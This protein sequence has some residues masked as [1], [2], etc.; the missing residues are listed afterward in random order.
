MGDEIADR[1]AERF[2]GGHEHPVVTHHPRT[3]VPLLFVN[4]GYTRSIAGLDEADSA[5]LLAELFAAFAEP[6][7]QFTRQWSEGD[8]VIWDEHRTVHRGPNDFGTAT[9]EL[10]R[11]TAGRIRPT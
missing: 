1:V 2:G 9:R 5:D 6:S 8:V 7:R 11:C 10:H 4:P 3:G